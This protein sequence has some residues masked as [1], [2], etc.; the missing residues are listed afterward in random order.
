MK[1]VNAYTADDFYGTWQLE[2]WQETSLDG[3]VIYPFGKNAQGYLLYT[4]DG[5]MSGVLMKKKRA[6]LGISLET[7]SEIKETLAKPWL[8][9]KVIKSARGLINYFK[10]AT[11]YLNYGGRFEVV[12]SQIIHHVDYSL[13]P[14]LIGGDQVRNVEFSKGRLTLSVR[15]GDRTQVLTWKKA[16]SSE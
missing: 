9:V 5:Y 13:I 4:N 8:I 3:K 12:G 6:H 11:T 2:S 10:G 16:R 15:M 1:P 14:D 7:L